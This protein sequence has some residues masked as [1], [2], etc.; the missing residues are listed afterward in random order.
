M[1]WQVPVRR[2]AALLLMVVL[3]L[4]LTPGAAAADIEITSV[5]VPSSVRAGTQMYFNVTVEN[6]GTSDISKA[7]DVTVDVFG[8][9]KTVEDYS[10]REGRRVTVPVRLT[11][12]RGASGPQTAEIT[13]SNP[14]DNDVETV[15]F[16]VEPFR[17]TLTLNP[18]TATVGEKV[19]VAG[20]MSTKNTEARLYVNGDY[21]TTVNSDNTGHYSTTFT[22]GEP[23]TTTVRIESGTTRAQ[24]FL[25][26]RPQLAITSIDAPTLVN[27]GESFQ[28]CT[29]FVW[30]GN[31][32]ASLQ[33]ATGDRSLHNTSI[34]PATDGR[35]CTDITLRDTG[36]HPVTV[37]AR[38]SGASARAQQ[39]IR[40]V[41]HDVQVSVEPQAFTLDTGQAAV[42]RIDIANDATA[43]RTF[44]ITLAG[45]ENLTTATERTVA[46]GR[47]ESQ[48]V[49]VRLVAPTEGTFEGN[50]TVESGSTI[51]ETRTVTVEARTPKSLQGTVL[52]TIQERLGGLADTAQRQRYSIIT[53]VV[54]AILLLLLWLYR[55]SH[56]A[57]L[58]PRH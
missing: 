38:H 31:E 43:A 27:S 9:E 12:P 23:G 40:V 37:T 52:G 18:D 49:F 45:M 55:R 28:F 48:T 2:T 15:D 39:D 57:V 1:H 35:H 5:T 7:L 25:Q 21:L 54:V 32:G 24:K 36:T 41:E 13:A 33:I 17:M 16:D 44:T 6:R 56:H 26:V 11:V 20:V 29:S 4:G 3:F 19:R 8:Q 14:G 47:G 51:S 42:L 46:L 50:V 58:E 10:V 34:A 30:S 53:G 22:A